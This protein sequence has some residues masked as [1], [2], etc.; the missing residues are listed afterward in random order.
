VSTILADN[1]NDPRDAVQRPGARHR[2]SSLP[3]VIDPTQPPLE[4]ALLT[5]AQARAIL[6]DPMRDLAYLDTRL[7]P[8]VE[9]YIAWKKLGRVKKST[10]DTYER[11]LARLAVGLPP[12]VGIAELDV[13]D[14][15]LYLNTVPPDSWAHDRT[16]INGFI[17][18]A[19]EFDHRS[20]KN[21]IKRLPKM[22]PGPQRTIKVFTEREM[23]AIIAA[24]RFMDDPVRDRARAQLLFDSGCRKAEVRMLQHRSIDPARKLITVIGKGD[25]ERDI[26]IDGDFWLAYERS[27]FEPIPRLDRLPEPDDYFWFPMRVAGE[28]KGRE[29]QVTKSYP[30]RP[31]G[32]RGMHLWWTR[33]VAHSEVTYRKPHTTRHTY[34]TAAL[35]A[36]EGDLYGVQQLLGHASVRTTELYLHAGKKAKESVARKL[37]A[38]RRRAREED[39]S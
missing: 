27:L 26:P 23:D 9:A 17:E 4:V 25:K 22:M 29:R 13:A 16:I 11:R 18:W 34:A 32:S 31:M 30:E 21:P 38:A 39:E 10:I 19:I 5:L 28:Y 1:T 36:S 35:D 12:G 3:C 37:A 8:M 14:L 15:S 6:A 33:L 7:G 20:A 2:R 24:S